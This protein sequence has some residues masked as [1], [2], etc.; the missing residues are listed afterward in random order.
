MN[1]QVPERDQDQNQQVIP[2]AP[3]APITSSP[4]ADAAALQAIDALEAETEIEAEPV[5]SAEPLSSR[6][7]ESSV[8]PNVES[9]STVNTFGTPEVSSDAT[10]PLNEATPQT[11]GQDTTPGVPEAPVESS[12]PPV[13][14]VAPAAPQAN[15][16]FASQPAA[17]KNTTLIIVA[18]AVIVI[19]GIVAGY[20]AWQ[21]LDS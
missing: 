20:F 12:T 6:P 3:V 11:F 14:P 13:V 4:E 7:M 21:A 1:P 19:A 9:S 15:E 17:K 5:V 18:V 8:S 16:P 10:S 2:P